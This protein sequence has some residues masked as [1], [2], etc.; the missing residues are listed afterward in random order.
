MFIKFYRVDNFDMC[1]IGGMGLGLVIV[2][3]IVKVY[4]GDI[5]V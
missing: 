2:K 5:I 3:E 1:K 4:G